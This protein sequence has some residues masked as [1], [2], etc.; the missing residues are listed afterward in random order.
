ML[1]EDSSGKRT[2]GVFLQHCSKGGRGTLVQT[3]VKIKNSHYIMH[4]VGGIKFT[5]ECVRI[6][7]AY[8]IEPLEELD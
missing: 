6:S 7:S 5:R 4:E 1:D 2:G 3:V 8:K